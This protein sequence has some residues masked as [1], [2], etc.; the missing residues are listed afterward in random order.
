MPRDSFEHSTFV[1][2]ATGFRF[3]DDFAPL[4]FSWLHCY[5]SLWWAVDLWSYSVAQIWLAQWWRLDHLIWRSCPS[6]RQWYC[7]ISWMSYYGLSSCVLKCFVFRGF[8][9]CSCL[10]FAGLNWEWQNP[11]SRARRFSYWLLAQRVF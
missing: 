7:F 2:F 11:G 4:T 5:L 9:R 3:A 8:W 1:S 6:E 10:Q